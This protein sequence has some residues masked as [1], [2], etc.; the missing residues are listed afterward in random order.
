MRSV[1]YRER[2]VA[3]LVAVSVLA[4]VGM[5]TLTGFALARVERLAGLAA[6]ARVQ[7]LGAAEAALSEAMLGWSSA[8]T[9]PAPGESTALVSLVLPGPVRGQALVR[10]LGGAVFA[11][12]ASGARLSVSGELL[13][14]VRMELLVLLDAADSNSFLHPRAY[15]R[16]WGLLP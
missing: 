13:G 11:I 4:A 7:A 2:G 1:S 12:E 15:P 3:L 10:A 5:I 6:V 16:G 8:Q 14:S 9:P